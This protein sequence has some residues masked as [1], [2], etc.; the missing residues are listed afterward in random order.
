MKVFWVVWYLVNCEFNVPVLKPLLAYEGPSF[1][2]FWL[3]L[4]PSQYGRLCCSVSGR[5]FAK[6]EPG[7]IW[8]DQS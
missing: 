5:I 2:L 7:L 6:A 8:A 4:H 3:N 1:G